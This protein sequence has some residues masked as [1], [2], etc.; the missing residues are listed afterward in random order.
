MFFTLASSKAACVISIIV[1]DSGVFLRIVQSKTQHQPGV[2]AKHHEV[3][4]NWKVK[5]LDCF[6]LAELSSLT[7]LDFIQSNL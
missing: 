4:S 3:V 2:M 6:T 7:L 1:F 5:V